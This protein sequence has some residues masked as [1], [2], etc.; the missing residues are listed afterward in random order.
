MYVCLVLFFSLSFFFRPLYCLSFLDLRLWLHLWYLQS[1]HTMAK[2]KRKKAQLVIYKTLHRI[3]L[4]IDTF[5]YSPKYLKGHVKWLRLKVSWI[6]IYQCNQCLSPHWWRKLEDP[7]KTT[8]LP[9]VTH[10]PYH[11]ILYRKYFG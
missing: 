6:S 11:T 1:F 2:S 7:E 4:Q 10:N 8:D 9:Q 3:L 5:Y